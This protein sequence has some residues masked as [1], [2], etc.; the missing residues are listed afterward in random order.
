MGFSTTVGSSKG[1]GGQG[2][3]PYF[4]SSKQSIPEPSAPKDN[5]YVLK[6]IQLKDT[7]I[8]AQLTAVRE[9]KIMSELP[10]NQNI[11]RYIT[12][13]SEHDHLNILMEYASKGDMY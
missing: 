13:F 9:A 1:T 5:L 10:E 12:S 8:K 3:L 7:K 4:G 2:N 6:K 11:I